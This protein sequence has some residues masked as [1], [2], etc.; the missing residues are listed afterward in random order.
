INGLSEDLTNDK[1]SRDGLSADLFPLTE[2]AQSQYRFELKGMEKY[3][4]RDVYRVKF[5][6][7]G[8]RDID[9]GVWKGEAFIDTS[10]CQPVFIQTSLALQIPGAVKVLLGTN[11]KG[12]GFAV[13]YQKFEDGIWFPV[14]YG[15]EFEV[16]AVFFYK[17]KISVA[18]SNLDF[19]CAHVD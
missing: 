12:L 3:R 18:M 15:G 8:K 14:S 17:R 9:E 13:S 7:N 11:I 16:R 4:G 1:Q 19:R 5:E 6:P 2:K 10:E